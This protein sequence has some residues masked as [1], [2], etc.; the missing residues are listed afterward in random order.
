MP[1]SGEDPESIAISSA[2]AIASLVRVHQEEYGIS[3]SHVFA[4]FAVNLALFVLLD[5]DVYDTYDP[6]CI[7]LTSAFA[8]ITTRSILGREVRSIFRRSVSKSKQNGVSKWDRLPEGLREI[9][10]EDPDESSDSEGDHHDEHEH[11]DVSDKSNHDGNTSTRTTPLTPTEEDETQVQKSKK[12][13]GP[14]EGS[15]GLCEMLCR[16]ETLTLG[17]NDQVTG[18]K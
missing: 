4:L 17:R 11:D 10:Q 15:R 8:I 5:F 3:R 6:D 18:K 9:L 2:R 12:V 16:Y 7:S 13:R 1:E 14:Q